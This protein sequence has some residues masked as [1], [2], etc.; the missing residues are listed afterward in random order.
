[1]NRFPSLRAKTRKGEP[2]VVRA[3]EPGDAEAVLA[4]ERA[5]VAAGRG[6]VLTERDLEDEAA[7]ARALVAA[8]Y[9]DP[10]RGVRLVASVAGCLAGSAAIQRLRPGMLS[11]VATLSV[12][13][14]PRYQGRGLG[15]LLVE[16][17]LA[18]TDGPGC[19]D[20][21]VSRI[22][23]SVR[24]DNPRAIA[25]YRSLGFELEATRR[26][27]VRSPGGALIDDHIMVRFRG[28]GAR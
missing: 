24:A 11:H 17:A 4:L 22:E 12:G 27:Y 19:A 25:L 26:G 15:R 1:M 6:V 2:V 14:D 10:R 21:P 23:L 13:V 7:L 9:R 3:I 8:A 5:I 28:G 18:W 20:P 16:R